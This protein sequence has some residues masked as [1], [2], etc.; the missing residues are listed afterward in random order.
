MYIPDTSVTTSEIFSISISLLSSFIYKK[1]Y[2]KFIYSSSIWNDVPLDVDY[3]PS[4]SI[5][6]V[7]TKNFL[8]NFLSC[9]LKA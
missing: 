6:R 5:L 1:S 7:L 3:V 4:S 9:C 2:S 8:Q